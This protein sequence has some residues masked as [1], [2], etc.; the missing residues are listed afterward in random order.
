MRVLRSGMKGQFPG[1]EIDGDVTQFQQVHANDGVDIPGKL[2]IAGQM[3]NQHDNVVCAGGIERNF[4]EGSGFPL[5][6]SVKVETLCRLA[7]QFQ[8]SCNSLVDNANGRARVQDE[9]QV[10][11]GSD[12]AFDLDK[13][14]G[15]E[16]EGQFAAR[17]GFRNAVSP[18]KSATQY[19]AKKVRSSGRAGE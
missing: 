15:I 18:G 19:Q 3:A 4:R 9:L 10:G 5:E 7:L 16:P 1:R 6:V 14:P 8:F 17:R 11:L 13:V 2:G 12:A